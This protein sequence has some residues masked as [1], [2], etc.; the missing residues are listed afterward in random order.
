MFDSNI[1][2]DSA[3][4]FEIPK[5]HTLEPNPENGVLNGIFI[6][7]GKYKQIVA[8]YNFKDG[9]RDGMCRF[10]KNGCLKIYIYENDDK[11]YECKKSEELDGYWDFVDNGL[12][13]KCCKFD[14]NYKENGV[15]YVFE[16]GRIAR[17]VEFGNGVERR[18]IKTFEE[19]V[20]T[21]RDENGQVVYIGDYCDDLKENYCR[22]GKKGMEI[23]KGNLVYVGEWKKNKKNGYGK[24][25]V[26]GFAEYEGEWK[27]NLPDGEGIWVENDEIKY[28]GIWERGFL[29]TSYTIF[30]YNTKEVD[31]DV[32]LKKVTISN[33]T[34]LRQLV[35]ASEEKK[36]EV[37]E[38]WVNENCCNDMKNEDL[39][40]SGFYNLEKIYVKNRSLQNL[41]S[42][43]ICNNKLLKSIECNGYYYDGY[44]RKEGGAFLNVKRVII[45]ST[46]NS[47]YSLSIS[48]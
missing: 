18:V 17:V 38:L 44:Y 16:E 6:E 21:E 13:V 34:E 35:N 25:L 29:N 30:N 42:L 2:V 7:R 46:C 47:D 31:V 33:S 19:G 1:K 5:D 15:G 26:N 36:F 39:V 12:R 45:E 23:Q 3:K 24:S 8:V 10:Y 9:K 27:D 22:E 37:K 11:K 32:E 40:I 14:D 41:N 28:E 20:M 43:K 4:K 48:S